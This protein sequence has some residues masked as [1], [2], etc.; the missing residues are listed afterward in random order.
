MAVRYLYGSSADA[1]AGQ[2]INRDQARD[3][4]FFQSL[5]AQRAAQA[6]LDQQAQAQA[7]FAA[8]ERERM[9]Y[10]ARAA[11]ANRLAYNKQQQALELGYERVAAQ[12]DLGDER[13]RF[14][15]AKMMQDRQLAEDRLGLQADRYQ[16][17]SERASPSDV[18]L[19]QMEADESDI[20][21]AVERY[22]TL[23]QQKDAL[24]EAR[25]R[26]G[27]MESRQ[28]RF[29][30]ANTKWYLPDASNARDAFVNKAEESLREFYPAGLPAGHT[31]KMPLKDRVALADKELE[32]RLQD[33]DQQLEILMESGVTKYLNRPPTAT[34]ALPTAAPPLL[35]RPMAATAAP[36]EV[37]LGGGGGGSPVA[38]ARV[39]ADAKAAIVNLRKPRDLVIQTAKEKYG[40]DLTPHL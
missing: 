40:I 26:L 18:R 19:A 22:R 38:L 15:E 6:Q 4:R 27:A 20:N 37:P 32:T 14:L 35:E 33:I 39:I 24:R 21:S 28:N 23:K 10:A 17:L 9:E 13:N 16:F 12:R 5:A 3:S 30:D 34:T 29:I 7:Q 31:A 8:Q 1:I 11:A 2:E 36:S 25:T